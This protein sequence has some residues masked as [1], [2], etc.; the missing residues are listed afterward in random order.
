MHHLCKVLSTCNSTVIQLQ[1][2]SWLR[3]KCLANATYMVEM[4]TSALAEYVILMGPLISALLLML[5]SISRE[6][7][8]RIE[9]IARSSSSLPTMNAVNLQ[10]RV[11]RF[12]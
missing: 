10:I 5:V 2:A 12:V 9:T 3:S 7:V 11:T 8:R 4:S 6:E 1:L